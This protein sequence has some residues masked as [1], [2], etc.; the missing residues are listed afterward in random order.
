MNKNIKLDFTDDISQFL[1]SLKKKNVFFLIDKNVNVLYNSLFSAFNC[2]VISSGEQAKQLK[3]TEKIIKRMLAYNVQRDTLLVGVGGG[4]VTDITG[5]IGSVYM[6]GMSFGFIPSTLLGMCDASV[7]GKNGVNCG[8]IKNI[9]GTINQPHF[10]VVWAD[11]LKTLTEN[12]FC[13]GMIEVIKHALLSG[14]D[15]VEFLLKNKNEIKTLKQ[16]FINEMIHRS[17]SYKFSVVMEDEQ[18]NNIRHILNYGHTIAHALEI[19]SGLSHGECVAAGI[20]IDT[21]ISYNL[22]MCTK[23]FVHL[24]A[25]L[26]GD[27]GLSDRIPFQTED[28]LKKITC[29]KKRREDYIRY[30]LPISP[31]NCKIVN[32]KFEE[33]YEYLKCIED[34]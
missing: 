31:G 26:C 23:E 3:Y 28:L 17:A 5:F 19:D 25:R 10:I 24:V 34:E 20:N 15:F 7:G 32:M 29:D 11:F 18:D 9:I 27:Y 8:L 12:E 16:P 14:N 4:V 1:S 33:L 2:F 13:N 21:K 30:V 6:R 22:G